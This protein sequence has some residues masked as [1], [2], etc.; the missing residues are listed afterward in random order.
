MSTGLVFLFCNEKKITKEEINRILKRVRSRKRRGMWPE[1]LSKTV[2]PVLLE[3]RACERE[4][5]C[6][7][8]V[9]EL[10]KREQELVVASVTFATS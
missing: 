5:L 2:A 1:L 10:G 6:R 8:I 7:D 4:D 9:K 3:R